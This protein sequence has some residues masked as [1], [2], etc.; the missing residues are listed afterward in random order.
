MTQRKAYIIYRTK[1]TAEKHA[2]S[3]EKGIKSAMPKLVTIKKC[4]GG[5]TTKF[6]KKGM[7]AK[8][9]LP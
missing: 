8:R 2:R 1:S 6:T 4:K 9:L 7:I 5:Y 3:S